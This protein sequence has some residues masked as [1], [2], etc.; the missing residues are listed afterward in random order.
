[1]Y[2]CAICGYSSNVRQEFV[3]FMDTVKTD[4]VV[5]RSRRKG[6]GVNKED[7]KYICIKCS[8]EMYSEETRGPR[9]V[10]VTCPKCGE[11]IDVWL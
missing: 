8:V 2:V 7:I 10:R 11:V 9:S 4:T 6:R 3:E 5:E 1:M